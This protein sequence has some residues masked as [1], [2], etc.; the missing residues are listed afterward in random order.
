MNLVICKKFHNI[1]PSNQSTQLTFL[2]S[3]GN[4]SNNQNSIVKTIIPMVFTTDI[5]VLRVL[6]IP[7]NSNQ[8][9]N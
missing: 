9:P 4:P 6:D 7:L 5:L 2:Q 1:G 8:L 3:I